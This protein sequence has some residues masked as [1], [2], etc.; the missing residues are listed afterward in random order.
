MSESQTNVFLKP[1]VGNL[2]IY[3]T[4]CG[5]AVPSS[6]SIWFA[7]RGPTSFE[8]FPMFLAAYSSLSQPFA[9]FHSLSRPFAAFH[10]LSQPFAAFRGLS[11][12]LWPFAAL[13]GLSQHFAAFRGIAQLKMT[14]FEDNN[15]RWYKWKKTL[16]KDKLNEIWPQ[17]KRT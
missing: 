14:L 5:W 1:V 6:G 17:R 12:P 4:I 9:T 10:G 8:S 15:G 3:K 11:R 7:Q 16:I 2:T 13:R